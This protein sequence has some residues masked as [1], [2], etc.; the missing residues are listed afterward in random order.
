MAQIKSAK[1]IESGSFSSLL[2]KFKKVI[3]NTKRFNGAFCK[4]RTK[5]VAN[6]KQFYV[7]A[8][9][10]GELLLEWSLLTDRFGTELMVTT[11]KKD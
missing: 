1:L 6:G 9:K 8:A 7:T 2:P 3:Q 4:Y 5:T 10:T 11:Y